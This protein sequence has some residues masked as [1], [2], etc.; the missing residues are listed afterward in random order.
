MSDHIY[1]VDGSGF[2]FR[3]FYALPSLSRTDGTPVG[4]V[5]GFVNMMLKLIDDFKASHLAVVFDAGRKTFRNDLYPDYKANRSE[6]PEDLIPQF[7]L[8]RQ[9]C[10]A[11]Q[12]QSLEQE[13]YEAD[14]LIATYT[15][16][17]RAQGLQVTIVSSD[18][19]L[20]QLVGPGVDMF[21]PVKNKT[22]GPDQVVEK[23]GVGP[24]RV[25][26]MQA[27]IGDGSD[28]IPG[29]PGVGPKTALELIQ[30]FG[31]LEGVLSR[32][33][34]IPQARRRQLILEHQELA[35]LSYQLVSL[36]AQVPHACEIE[37]LRV[38]KGGI[39]PLIT[40]LEAQNFSSV[41]KRLKRTEHLEEPTLFS[42]L[43]ELA[44]RVTSREGLQAWLEKKTKATGLLAVEGC[45]SGH[46][47]Q[48]RLVALALAS[49]GAQTLVDLGD[50][51]GVLTL[52]AD[53][54]LLKVGHNLKTLMR[55]MVIQG[56]S[57][58][59]VEDVMVLSYV[60][61]N[62]L[63][64]HDLATLARTYLQVSQGAFEGEVDLS[65]TTL[66]ELESRLLARVEVMEPLYE[67]LKHDLATER[68]TTVYETLERPLLNILSAME[69]TGILVEP[70]TL[71]TL[72]VLFE[73]ELARLEGEIHQLAGR[74]FNI[75][76]PKQL[77][78]ILFE[79]LK[80]PLGKKGVKTGA[81]VT[82]AEVLEELASLGHVLPEKML[83][84]R[85]LA[86]L[87]STYTDAL[88]C[89]ISPDTGRIHTEFSMTK[90]TT[91][92]L[93][94]LEPNLQN[95]PVRTPAGMRI[96]EAFLAPEGMALVSFDYS[97]IELR[98]LAHVAQIKPLQEAFAQDLDIHALTASQVFG[99]PLGA[100]T[101]EL[102]QRAKAINFGIIYGISAFGLARQI[103][104]SR[105]QAQAYMNAYFQQYPGIK[106]YMDETILTA[107]THG[108]VTTPW[109]RRCYSSG[110]SDAHMG[111]RQMAQRQAINAPLQGGAA[112]II[113]RA[114]VRLGGV[115]LPPGARLLLQVHD[116][117][118]FE[119]PE[120]AVPALIACVQ[121]L[122]EGCVTLSVPL[123]VDVS[124]GKRWSDL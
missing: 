103:K 39:E 24:E 4:A 68:M 21:D 110:L 117:L 5:L 102:R 59:P 35:R 3:A 51:K 30:A 124:W 85:G 10:A 109:G 75:A 87:K 50:V 88:L 118:M 2:I 64:G 34:E 112:D 89:E 99:L 27:L 67:A 122:M 41:I 65:K 32:A 113:K 36:D 77:G 55:L 26:D 70:G 111:R 16:L 1:L 6:T 92:R 123:K 107:K 56:L 54:T 33:E 49:G 52:I 48:V 97:Q 18:K 45:L 61:A 76:S 116:E 23:F 57:M 58:G 100:V 37:A 120:G 72:S 60:L 29:V 13:G 71:K 42:H 108:Y 96:R 8:I 19:D 90:T 83:E 15:R 38:K 93:S 40:F 63:H 47:D 81:Y 44:P 22:I 78:E 25:R 53:P 95:I 31:S 115:T 105:G 73:K 79:E 69:A 119:V 62:G 43:K 74:P 7:S 98:L 20:M 104:E 94:S 84:W 82:N 101:P 12:I 66:E 9:A 114:M 86:K 46:G 11:F 28:N 91:G 121:P 80:L 17:A 14:D 106:A